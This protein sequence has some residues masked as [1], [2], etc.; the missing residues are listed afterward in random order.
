MKKENI[1][2]PEQN[3]H[4]LKTRE[5]QRMNG[6][7]FSFVLSSKDLHCHQRAFVVKVTGVKGC[8]DHSL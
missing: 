1:A 3:T 5:E 6:S 4:T 2:E 7:E 8:N